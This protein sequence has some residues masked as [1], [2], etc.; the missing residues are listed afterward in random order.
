MLRR[1]RRRQLAP[2]VRLL[3]WVGVGVIGLAIAAVGVAVLLGPV[4]ASATTHDVGRAAAVNATR[5][6]LL[7]VAGGLVATIS[8]AFTAR[9]FFLSRR[10]QLTDRYGRAITQ[11][12]SERLTERLGG[13]YALEHL[14]RE[15]PRDHHTVVEVLA[16]FIRERVPVAAHSVD[17]ASTSKGGDQRPRP[18]TD[19]QAALTVL[20]RRPIRTEPAAV[21]LSGVDLRGADM[22]GLHLKGVQFAGAD[23]RYAILRMANLETAYLQRVSLDH[24][25]LYRVRMPM[26]ELHRSTLRTADLCEADLDRCDLSHA[27]LAGCDLSGAV[28]RSANLSCANLYDAK[29]S[30][31]DLR[32]ADL[33]DIARD[34]PVRWTRRQR[35]QP[36]Q[37]SDQAA[38]TEVRLTRAQLEQARTDSTT[39]LPDGLDGQIGAETP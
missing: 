9:T 24:A 5:Q 20:G 37:V 8:L 19:V 12:A 30:Q 4:A 33:S 35:S 25:N 29:L 26:A 31:A 18:P 13:V 10:G 34:G 38:A 7:L 1:T 11:L 39:Q 2:G 36:A 14:M 6:I 17:E 21:N 32:G 16:A 15:S 28:L 23:L 27:D 22:T 3:G